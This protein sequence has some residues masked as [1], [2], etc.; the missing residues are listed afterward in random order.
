VSGLGHEPHGHCHHH[1][2]ASEC[3]LCTYMAFEKLAD[4]RLLELIR[5]ETA[6][7]SAEDVETSG[8]TGLDCA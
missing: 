5:N 4:N 1:V 3:T 2:T 8:G 6:E 7:T